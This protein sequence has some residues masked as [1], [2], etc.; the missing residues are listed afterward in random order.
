MNTQS[1]PTR[2]SDPPPRFFFG[3]VVVGAA[4]VTLFIAFG[5][6]YSFA[7]FFPSLQSEFNASRGAGS[8]VFS[9][10]GFLF[11]TFG[12][13]SGPLADRMDGR[14]VIIAGMVMTA[15]GLAAASFAQS[16]WQVYLAYGLGVGLG[17][18]FIYVPTL[19]IVQR[20]FRARRG[21][22]SGIAVSGIGLGTLVVPSVATQIIALG[23]WRVTYLLMALMP[24]V[25]G[26]VVALFLPS[27]PA[28]RGLYPDGVP[29]KEETL[30]SGPVAAYAPSIRQAVRTKPFLLLYAAGFV[31]SFAVL[32]PFAH[33]AAYAMDQ[34]HS[35]QQGVFLIGLIG[36]GS[37]LGRFAMGG[38]A[39][40]I[41]RG[42]AL[43]LMYAG[44]GLAMLVW[45]VSSG[46]GALVFLAIFFGLFYGGMVALLPAITADYFEGGAISG[47]IGVLYTHISIGVLIGPSL[48]GYA[49]DLFGSYSVPLIV[50]FALNLVSA[51][52]IF[53]LPPAAAWRAGQISG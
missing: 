52:L 34:G 7:A 38:A 13:V 45:L 31:H 48:A 23:G 15:V 44:M 6:A 8:M 21:L 10:S 29:P 2:R 51:L 19:G 36:L 25:G 16:L 39:D 24:L 11:F 27:S 5:I 42:L 3:W 35:E 22:A 18:G 53:T 49:Y 26:M 30:A 50:G 37:I 12:A 14:K 20:W 28:R 43:G 32:I 46:Y 1:E 40:R 47:I 4:F 33:L 17:V 9:I 41:G